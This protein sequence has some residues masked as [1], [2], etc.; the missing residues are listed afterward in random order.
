[1]R[2]KRVALGLQIANSTIHPSCMHVTLT[3]RPWGVHMVTKLGASLSRP[4]C[5]MGSTGRAIRKYQVYP[6]HSSR[7][8]Q[9][10]NNMN[11]NK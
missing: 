9:V 2:A 3:T 6:G 8:T 11:M 10:E 1:M 5:G 4:C 7:C